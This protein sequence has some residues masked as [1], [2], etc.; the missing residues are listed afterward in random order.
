MAKPLEKVFAANDINHDT[1]L[2]PSSGY[3]YLKLDLLHKKGEEGNSSLDPEDFD[4]FAPRTTTRI[5]LEQPVLAE[6]VSVDHEAHTVTIDLPLGD[7]R[8][9][10]T[11][12][13]DLEDF[14]SI[15][16]DGSYIQ[17]CPAS[18]ASDEKGLGYEI[19]SERAPLENGDTVTTPSG[20]AFR[21]SDVGGSKPE[22]IYLTALQ[23]EFHEQVSLTRLTE[24]DG[25]LIFASQG[26]PLGDRRPR[27]LGDRNEAD[28]KNFP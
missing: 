26:H 7:G 23:D 25:R 28:G 6:V 4:G 16:P 15:P 13:V 17:V 9:S 1:P 3:K 27:P 18:K 12:P 8:S 22:Q 10:E 5:A 19:D 20:K 24:D 14:R 2:H 11:I 21:V